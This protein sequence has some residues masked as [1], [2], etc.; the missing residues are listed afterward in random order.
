MYF[1]CSATGPWVAVEWE[2]ARLLVPE[3]VALPAEPLGSPFQRTQQLHAGLAAVQPPL[4]PT[5]NM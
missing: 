1:T 5:Q 3:G 4:V 2:Q